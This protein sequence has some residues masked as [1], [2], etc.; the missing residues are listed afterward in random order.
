MNSAPPGAPSP[1]SANSGSESE[2]PT[3]SGEMPV[4]GLTRGS[5]LAG[6]TFWNLVGTAF[7]LLVAIFCIPLLK[8][9]LGTDRLKNIAAAFIPARVPC[10]RCTVSHC[11]T[12]GHWIIE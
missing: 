1:V 7:P 8:R 12:S 11:A 3:A 9:S 10:E 4:K 2:I 6:N 5:L